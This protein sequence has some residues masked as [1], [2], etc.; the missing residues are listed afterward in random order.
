MIRVHVSTFIVCA[1]HVLTTD[2]CRID[3]CLFQQLG[4]SDFWS[5]NRNKKCNIMA[6]GLNALDGVSG[7]TCMG[8]TVRIIP[9]HVCVERVHSFGQ[10][11]A[12]FQHLFCP[13]FIS[14]GT[15]CVW[16]LHFLLLMLFFVLV[17]GDA[18]SL[19]FWFY[20]S[21]FWRRIR[22]V[23]HLPPS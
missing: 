21:S 22:V 1:D 8:A 19:G 15:R 6:T 12:S 9:V 5:P 10:L 18:F 23:N 13:H 4:S 3:F 2:I 17:L 14:V 11:C 7:V 20:C 16:R